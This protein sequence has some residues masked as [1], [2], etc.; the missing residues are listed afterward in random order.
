MVKREKHVL[1]TAE[2]ILPRLARSKVFTSLDAASGFYQVP[3]REDSKKLTTFITPFGRYAFG[4]LLF[5]I[6]SAPEIFQRKMAETLVGLEGTEVY[7]DDI[8]I[9]GETEEIHDQRL[10]KALKVIEEAGL[11]LNNASVSSDKARFV[12]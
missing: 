2:E 3:L 11:K 10:D 5:G 12:F 7:I 8:L 6:T 4:R 1:P 9:H